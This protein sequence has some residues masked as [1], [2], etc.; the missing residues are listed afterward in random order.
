MQDVL[1]VEVLKRE[2]DL[3]Q[4]VSDLVLQKIFNNK[5][6]F[7]F[8]LVNGATLCPFTLMQILKK[9]LPDSDKN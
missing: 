9:K 6:V 7:K 1:L 2:A 4:P 3:D 8:T 5:T